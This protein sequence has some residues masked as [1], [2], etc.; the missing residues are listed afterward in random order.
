MN[1]EMHFRVFWIAELAVRNV[2]ESQLARLVDGGT[3]AHAS[4]DS[5]V[6]PLLSDPTYD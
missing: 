5:D 1:L 6:E 2:L 4:E 3:R